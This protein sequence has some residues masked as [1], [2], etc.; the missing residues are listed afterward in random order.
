MPLPNNRSAGMLIDSAYQIYREE[1][2]PD[3][4]AFDPVFQRMSTGSAVL[5]DRASE[6][7]DCI[8]SDI[9]K[10]YLTEYSGSAWNERVEIVSDRITRCIYDNY[11]HQPT[12]IRA[13]CE[14]WFNEMTELARV[15][16]EGI[17][18][19]ISVK[20]VPVRL[21]SHGIQIANPMWNAISRDQASGLLLRVE[22]GTSR[23]KEWWRALLLYLCYIRSSGLLSSESFRSGPGQATIFR[24]HVGLK[25]DASPLGWA[26]LFWFMTASELPTQPVHRLMPMV[27]LMG[28]VSN[29]L[30]QWIHPSIATCTVA[31]N[32]PTFSTRSRS[33][34]DVE[35]AHCG[36]YIA[37]SSATT[38]VSRQGDRVSYCN[39][40]VRGAS[41]C[42]SCGQPAAYIY[43]D[44][45]CWHCSPRAAGPVVQSY[46]ADPCFN[47]RGG[48]E[49]HF[50]VE[51]EVVAKPQ[52]NRDPVAR[53]MIHYW[54]GDAICKNDG[55]LPAGGIELATSPGTLDWQRE[56]WTGFFKTDVC[57]NELQSWTSNQC[58]LHVHISRYAFSQLTAALCGTF[59]THNGIRDWLEDMFGRSCGDYCRHPGTQSV[60]TNLSF[61]G[62]RYYLWNLT[63]DNTFEVRGFKGTL[64][65]RRLLSCLDFCD[66]LIDYSARTD[67]S[68][69]MMC[70]KQRF[71]DFV[72]GQYNRWPYLGNRFKY[73]IAWVKGR[74]KGDPIQIPAECEIEEV[75]G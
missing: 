3:A 74:E 62:Q 64:N 37:R 68:V 6:Y 27:P 73:G 56:K 57:R 46:S 31:S 20:S 12:R 10:E 61:N 28:E 42:G 65:P 75:S 38:L 19:P 59:M 18:L 7:S 55:S 66:A 2:S 24:A 8:L 21:G 52:S 23:R 34:G 47:P 26:I 30:M 72:L 53:K 35:C 69:A 13:L 36:D 17:R 43:Q 5:R 70:D 49:R 25:L 67:L 4:I 22:D 9:S 58:G 32:V 11:D 33:D 50:G 1:L 29:G 63:N 14:A 39:R 54:K 15:A 16:G 44:G 60:A 48:G 45:F 41:R 51:L 71:I 40:C